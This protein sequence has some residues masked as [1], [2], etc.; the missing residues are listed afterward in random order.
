MAIVGISLALGTLR[1]SF[2]SAL[3]FAIISYLLAFVTVYVLAWIID[4]LA[5]TFG[6]TRNFANALK[7]SVY[8]YTPVWLT[9]IFLL[10]P[11]LWFLRILGLYGLYLMWLGLPVLMKA[12]ARENTTIGYFVAIIV[13]AIVIAYILSRVLGAIVG[14]PSF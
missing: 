8:S 5:P 7:L 11:G 3:V 14:I 12:P 9:G 4:A 2:I 1:V 13:V 6:A 10:L